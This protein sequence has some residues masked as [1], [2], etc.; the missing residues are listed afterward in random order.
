[1]CQDEYQ[2]EFDG[3]WRLETVTSSD[4]I[5]TNTLNILQSISFIIQNDKF[6]SIDSVDTSEYRYL[7]YINLLKESTIAYFH[8]D[9]IIVPV[10]LSPLDTSLGSVKMIDDQKIEIRFNYNSPRELWPISLIFIKT[11]QD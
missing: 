4:S 10:I 9:K 1:L 11:K 3:Y 5:N 2:S 7:K 6:I 8:I